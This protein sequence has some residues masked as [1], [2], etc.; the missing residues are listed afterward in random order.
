MDTSSERGL[1]Q[2]R[3][4]R[5]YA[6]PPQRV[7]VSRKLPGRIEA[8]LTDALPGIL[9]NDF[10]IRLNL[11]QRLKRLPLRVIIETSRAD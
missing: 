7:N 4:G 8:L 5:G 3:I 6:V 10:R 1:E 9:T 2:P 11:P